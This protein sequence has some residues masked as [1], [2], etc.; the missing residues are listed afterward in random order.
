[1]RFLVHLNHPAHYHLCIKSIEELEKHGH[2]ILITY[3]EKDVLSGLLSNRNAINVSSGYRKKSRLGIVSNYLKREIKLYKIVKKFKP[4]L[5]FGTSGELIHV[6]KLLNIPMLFLAED[7]VKII[8]KLALTHYPFVS[9]VLSPVSCNNGFW[10]NKTIHYPG[11][12]ELA[13]LYPKSFKPNLEIVKKYLD[14]NIPY[15]MI[16]FSKLDAHHDRGING[17]ENELAL[18]I[19]ELAKPYGNIFI[20]SERKLEPEL[21]KYRINIIPKDIHHIM[22]YASLYIGD[23]QTMAAEAGMLGTPFIRFNDFVGRIGYLNEI[24]NVYNLGF[25]FLTDQADEM[26]EKVKELLSLKNIKILWQD[27][28]NIMIADKIDVSIFFVWLIENYPN[29]VKQIQN[30]PEFWKKFK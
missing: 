3:R 14:H 22:A 5:M 16:R 7:D 8:P 4:S 2:E 25:G 21:E 23:S 20:T 1:M 30:T 6:G 12:H 18:K 17:I 29:S 19:I 13:Y 10:N 28:R 24:E 11:F 15:I 26:L 9:Y 27:K